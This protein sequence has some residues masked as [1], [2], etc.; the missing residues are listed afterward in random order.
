V[1]ASIKIIPCPAIV[2]S[3]GFG[4]VFGWLLIFFHFRF[5]DMEFSTPQ[6]HFRFSPKS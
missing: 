6:A 4:G 3:N 2:S 1:N 5:T